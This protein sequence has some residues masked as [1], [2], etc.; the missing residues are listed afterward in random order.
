MMRFTK[1]QDETLVL[2]ATQSRAQVG[3]AAISIGSSPKRTRM[4]WLDAQKRDLRPTRCVLDESKAPSRASLPENDP[5]DHEQAPESKR[6]SVNHTADLR[7][8]ACVSRVAHTCFQGCVRRHGRGDE[9]LQL[10]LPSCRP[11]VTSL[12]VEACGTVTSPG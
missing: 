2:L 3:C 7:S 1:Y 6:G 4:Q 10:W 12:A 9:W 5:P 8:I 11:S